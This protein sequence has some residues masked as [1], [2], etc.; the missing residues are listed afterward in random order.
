MEKELWLRNRLFCW[1]SWLKARMHIFYLGTSG[2]E[3][4]EE[5]SCRRKAGW[6]NPMQPP[7][8]LR[9]SPPSPT[10]GSNALIP[11]FFFNLFRALGD[12]QER[13]Y[14]AIAPCHSSEHEGLGASA[15]VPPLRLPFPLVNLCP[16]P[17][18]CRVS[19]EK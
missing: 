19:W 3:A 2:W 4:A 16:L 12:S 11:F 8:A 17:L 10:D 1:I 5:G 7:L 9:P 6:K 14:G 18:F 15:S 13:R